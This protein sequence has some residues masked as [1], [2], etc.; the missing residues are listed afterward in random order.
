MGTEHGSPSG[1]LE[2]KSTKLCG[3]REEFYVVLV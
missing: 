1:G 2:D 3:D